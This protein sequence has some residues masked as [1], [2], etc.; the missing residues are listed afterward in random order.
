MLGAVMS[1]VSG[2]L[3]L[4]RRRWSRG[5]RNVGGD[6]RAQ[7]PEISLDLL[8]TLLRVVCLLIIDHKTLL[9]IGLELAYFA[10]IASETGLNTSHVGPMLHL[11]SLRFGLVLVI[12][13]L[14]LDLESSDFVL[15]MLV[16]VIVWRRLGAMIDVP[17]HALLLLHHLWLGGRG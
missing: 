11:K 2:L 7:G 15:E 3:R 10:A 8:E 9:L 14:N 6:L 13:A 16:V 17:G 12:Q 4:V 5:H 1:I